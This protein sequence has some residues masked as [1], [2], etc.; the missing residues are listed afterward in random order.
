MALALRSLCAPFREVLPGAGRAAPALRIQSGTITAL[1]SSCMVIP[2]SFAIFLNWEYISG[3][4]DCINL[5]A[6]IHPQIQ[7]RATLGYNPVEY[8]RIRFRF[9]PPIVDKLGMLLLSHRQQLHQRPHGDPI[10]TV[11]SALVSQDG[12]TYRLRLHA[13]ESLNGGPNGFAHS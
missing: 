6:V 9:L 11:F 13:L 12:H 5:V 3:S 4:R 10:D 1:M 7:Y 2:L 8:S